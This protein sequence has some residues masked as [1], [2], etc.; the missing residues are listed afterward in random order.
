MSVNIEL[1]E[2]IPHGHGGSFKRGIVAALTR[3]LDVR[4]END[5]PNGHDRSY[6][7]GIEL[8]E[9]LVREIARHV[10]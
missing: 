3:E 1:P 9:A 5:Q 2:G 6:R 10:R 8:G 4:N 7:R